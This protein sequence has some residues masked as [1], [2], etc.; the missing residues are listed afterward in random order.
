MSLPR[1]SEY[2]PSGVAWLG[3]VPGHWEILPIKYLLRDGYDGLKI[4]PFGSQLT[5]DMHAEGGEFK[6]YGQ[7]NVISRDFERGTRF[8]DK[9]KFEE[10]SVY[11][12]R[13]GDIL[14][15][16]MG[17]S[18]RCDVVP[19]DIQSG[20]MDS[21][22]LRLR[23]E[24]KIQSEFLRTLIDEAHYLA[25]QIQVMGKGSIMHGLNST[26]VK[27]LL[28]AVPSSQEQSHIM[29]FLDRETGKID[30]LI[31]EQRR[32]VELLA[33]K[34]QAVIS[35]A[36]TK[37]LNPHVPMKDSGIEWLG[38]V[39]AH[40]EV[41][42]LKYVGKAFGGLI[43]DPSEIVEEGY[44]MLVLRS[45]NVQNGR[46]VFDDNVYVTTAIPEKIITQNGDI[47]V[48]SRNGSRALIGKN[49]MIDSQSSG[50]T[51]G[52]FMMIFRSEYSGYIF[53]VFNSQLFKFQSGAFLTATINQLTVGNLYSMEVPLPHVDEQHT[54]TAYLNRENAQFDT[55]IAE[56]YRAIALL[57]ERRSAL[58]SA[59]VMGKI[60]VRR[61]D[62]MKEAA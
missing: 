59:A 41:K 7:E 52:A 61:L 49:A 2:K 17:T 26:I 33:E 36:V 15:T 62:T 6:V 24:P 44:G 13:A 23:V 3:E 11:E 34:R 46:I 57:Q 10:L 25:C 38:E 53:H 54:I 12:I 37:G 1:Y 58:I 27:C 19:H 21:H 16:M 22:L 43:Y 51:F 35:H 45:S 30:A 42:R 32:L 28:V 14:V 55:L 29:S 56:A 60:D 8:I 4:G 39:P 48:C 47:L 40:W 18:G 31:A 5:S 50:V 9:E 20:I